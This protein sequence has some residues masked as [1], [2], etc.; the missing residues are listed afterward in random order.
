MFVRSHPPISHHPFVCTTS[1]SY[2][3]LPC[4]GYKKTISFILYFSVH[5]MGNVTIFFTSKVFV[6]LFHRICIYIDEICLMLVQSCLRWWYLFILKENLILSWQFPVG[7]S[8]FLYYI[9]YFHLFF[10]VREVNFVIFLKRCRRN[11]VRKRIRNT[12]YFAWE[13]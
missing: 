10:Y 12:K 3:Q 2:I 4:D 9:L 13:D 11:H 5:S 7:F 1:T 6:V 8:R